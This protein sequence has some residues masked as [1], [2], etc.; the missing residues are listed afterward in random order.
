MAKG[1]SRQVI[2]LGAV[3]AALGG[4]L[5]LG[6]RRMRAN[7]EIE[8]RIRAL[9]PPP[10]KERFDPH[11][12]ADLPEPVRRYFLHALAEGA[13]LD[14]AVRLSMRGQIRIGVGGDWKRMRAEELLSPPRGFVWK[15]SAGEGLMRMTGADWMEGDTAGVRFFALGVVPVA[16]AAGFDVD[17]SAAGRLALESI[18]APAALLPERGV[19]WEVEGPDAIRATLRIAGEPH[20]LTLSLD[21]AGGVRAVSGLRWGSLEEG[22]PHS[23]IPFGADVD[24]ERTFGGVTIPS[25]V[26][27][28]WWYGTERIFEFFRAEVEVLP[29]GQGR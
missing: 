17:R 25:A 21:D 20:S 7:R 13:P 11:R 6:T 19:R 29:L 1:V 18:W 28:A 15:V 4:A 12:V 14:T 26:R 24:G 5:L 8:R 16:E 3:G 2:G 27:V 23:W 22:K 9:T 10:S